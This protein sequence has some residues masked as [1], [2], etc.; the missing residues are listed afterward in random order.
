MEE[1]WVL[2]TWRRKKW[3]ANRSREERKRK[4]GVE[5]RRRVEQEGKYRKIRESQRKSG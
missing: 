2:K 3:G 5:K 1:T 4:K